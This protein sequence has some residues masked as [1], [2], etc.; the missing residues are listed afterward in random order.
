MLGLYTLA[1][2]S[3]LLQTAIFPNLEWYWLSWIA[4]T[5]LLY[6]LL[7]KPRVQILT[8]GASAAYGE[9]TTRQG[10]WLG[11]FCGVIWYGCTCYWVY[12]VMN[13]YGGL[14]PVVAAGILV[15]FCLYLGLYHG[16]F[17]ALLVRAG[18]SW[19][20]AGAVCSA[21]LVGGSGIGACS[22]HGIPLGLVG[23]D[24]GE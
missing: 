15:L 13:T 24:A 11:Y 16:L 4:L 1:A 20:E 7:T 10:F 22:H 9:L 21:F 3:G 2:A 19:A 14:P 17:G 23:D 18:Q 6:A 12:H 8:P 5:P